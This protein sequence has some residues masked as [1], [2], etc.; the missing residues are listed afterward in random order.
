VNRNK[1]Q[2][3]AESIVTNNCQQHKTY[4]K[5]QTKTVFTKINTLMLP[6]I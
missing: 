3:A 4:T 6:K 1:L 2:H 5:T